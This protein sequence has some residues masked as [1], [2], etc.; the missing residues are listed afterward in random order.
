MPTQWRTIAPIV[1]RTATQCLERYQ[2]LLDDAE[3]QDNDELGL[4]GG[5][6]PEGKPA[7]IR[8]LKPGEIDTDPE[9][10]A[11][12]PD[13]ID[14]DD[15][16]KEMLSE[17]RARLANTQGKKAKRKARE[18]QLE[19]ARRLALL[20]KKREL[21]AA[22]INLRMKPKKKGM[23][24][25]A[26]IPFE[27]QPAPG[28]YDVTEE[29][30]KVYAAPVGQ[31]L[32]ALEGKRKTELE[33]MEEG[34]KRRKGNDEK[35]GGQATQFV[36]A[37]EAQIKKL[38]EAEQIIRRRK[39]NLPMPQV[40]EAELEE[41]VKIGQAGETARELVGNEGAGSD[42]TG[43]LLGDYESLGKARMA[44]TP[45]TAPQ[46]D[47]VM[48][49]ARNLRHMAMT[50]TPLLGDENTPLHGPDAAGTG[51]EGATP[52][53]STSATPNPLMTP[54][55]E[56]GSIMA[57]PRTG[58][59]GATP[60]RT[61]MRDS[62]SI[63]DAAS[64]YG[65][66]PR[67]QRVRE[68]AARRAL[69]AGFLSLPKPENNFE[70]AETEDD[71]EEEEEVVLTEEDAAERDAKLKAAREEEERLERERRSLVV[72]KGLPRPANVDLDQIVY[73]LNSTIDE[74]SEMTAAFQL[75]NLEVARLMK[76]DSLAHPLPG[77]T[78]PGGSLA[79]EYEMPLDDLVVQA[80]EAIHLELATGLG[81]PGASEAQIRLTIS[82]IAEEDVSAF[83]SSWSS[84]FE[85][86]VF[87]PSTKAWVET[88]SLSEDELSFCLQYMIGESKT[89]MIQ[90]ATKASKSEKKLAKQLGGY[91]VINN[92]VKKGIEDAIKEIHDSQREL[93]TFLML[94][95]L[96]ESGAPGRVEQKREEVRK[97]EIRE[98]DLQARYAELNDERRI[99][100]EAIEQLEEDILVGQA[101]LALEAQEALAGVDEMEMA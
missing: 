83:E 72:K 94:R 91:Q 53:N 18:R 11:A 45:R 48:A 51:F 6:A 81:L 75:V 40:G 101:Q 4:G 34:N 80:K 29:N 99:R 85:N 84:E 74:A 61:P 43:R 42:A 38:K 15:D 50:Q 16:E 71:E 41:I 69:K 68:Q 93:E 82:S 62:L 31:S 92:K 79:S 7:D 77:T 89:R 27:K 8:G 1:G 98:R 66:T 86:L 55:T 56:R 21:K 63:N 23:D 52:R 54:A 67:D 78:I 60:M 9:T 35:S 10:R 96:E 88:S 70:L 100:L 39:L 24:Y 87:N 64:S 37:R 65:E 19:E 20:Q 2:K 3:A 5:D 13:P 97:L 26:D 36:A 57:T 25:N 46:Q 12:R 58:V 95:G 47:N 28:F 22:G 59:P 44:R 90:D 33:E 73:E 30:A 32:R 49:E 17:A 76:H 14:M